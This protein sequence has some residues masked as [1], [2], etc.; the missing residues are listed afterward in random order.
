MKEWLSYWSGREGVFFI[1]TWKMHYPN[2]SLVIFKTHRDSLFDKVGMPY[3][4]AAR[5]RKNERD[6]KDSIKE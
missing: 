4:I 2:K 1:V 5:N 6:K 3:T